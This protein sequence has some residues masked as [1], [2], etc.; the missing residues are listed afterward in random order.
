MQNNKNDVTVNTTDVPRSYVLA[1]VSN[2]ALGRNIFHALVFP[3]GN[4]GIS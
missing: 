4:F 3:G 1:R 2:K